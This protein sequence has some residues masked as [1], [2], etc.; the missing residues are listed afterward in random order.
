MAAGVAFENVKIQILPKASKGQKSRTAGNRIHP[1][2]LPQL[3][4][5]GSTKCVR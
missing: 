3:I 4:I 5:S 2:K 1:Q